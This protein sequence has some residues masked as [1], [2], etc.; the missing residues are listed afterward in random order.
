ML[1]VQERTFQNCQFK[2]KLR[3]IELKWLFFVFTS[4]LLNHRRHYLPQMSS[5]LR[6]CAECIFQPCCFKVTEL[7]VEVF[8]LRNF[9]MT[10]HKCLSHRPDFRSRSQ[11]FSSWLY[12]VFI[13]FCKSRYRRFD[14]PS[15]PINRGLLCKVLYTGCVKQPEMLLECLHYPP[16]TQNDYFRRRH[17]NLPGGDNK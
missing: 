1:Y 10:Q 17:P 16:K 6:E 14:R 7:N 3:I 15:D 8:F 9:R 13:L 4:Y 5:I 12:S 11:N 2:I